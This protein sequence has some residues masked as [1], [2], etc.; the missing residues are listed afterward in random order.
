M[1][2]HPEHWWQLVPQKGAPEW[3]VLPQAALPGEVILSKRHE[4][5]V[6]SN[7]AHT[8]FVFRGKRY[9]SVE[10]LWQSMF[11]PE[12]ESDPRAQAGLVW[13]H[14]REEVSQMIA[15]EAQLAGEV[16]FA[17]MK[18]LGIDWV[19]FEGRRMTYWTPEKGEH[20]QLIVEIMGEKLKQNPRVRE[21]LLSTGDLILRPDHRQP[22]DAPPSWKYY[23]IWMDYRKRLSQ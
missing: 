17:H 23:E 6:L 7:F 11:Y 19:T 15:F 20:Y 18:T 8:P 12:N 21:A 2:S 14:T 5:G 3:E 1:T 4:L 9:E 13:P 10:G 16:G 22:A